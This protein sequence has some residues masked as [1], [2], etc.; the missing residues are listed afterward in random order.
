MVSV[1]TSLI[2]PRFCVADF[3]IIHF[4]GSKFAC[5][6][7]GSHAHGVNLAVASTV[8]FNSKTAPGTLR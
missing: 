7:W 5:S 4:R 6:F 2:Y 1:V 8:Y 3:E